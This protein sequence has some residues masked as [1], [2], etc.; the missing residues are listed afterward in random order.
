MPLE[1]EIAPGRMIGGNHPCFF[2]AEIGQNHQGDINIAKQMIQVAKDAGADCAKFQKSELKHKFNK[3]A[4][5][6]PYNSPHSWGATYGEHKE[7]LEF[8]HDQYR[9]LKAY[10]DSV[11]IILGASGMDDKAVDFLDELGIPFFKVGSGDTNNMP[12]LENTAKKGRPMIISSGMQTMS[13]MRQVY[14][15]VKPIND[16]FCFLQC[17]S[18]YPLEPE[19]VHLN[20]IKQY[21]KEFPDIPIGYSGHEGGMTITLAAV[22][23]GAKVVERHITMD[24][25]WKGNDH[26][27]SLEP[28]ELKELIA[29]IRVVER[30]MG[31]TVKDLQACEMGT[32]NKLGK[33]V[34]AACDIPAETPLTINMLAVKV[35]EPKGF[36]PERIYELVGKKLCKSVEFDDSILESNIQS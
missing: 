32:F 13:T 34:V 12:Y 36:P 27:A 15:T 7:F 14:K 21:Q 22:A 26:K 3:A 16:K 28:A 5:A 30:A 23:M 1:I 6:R 2:I 10:A 18:A 4:L 20:I 9:E 17:T 11:G 29:E 35:A 33:S 8:S 19:D 31:S 25:T 24:K